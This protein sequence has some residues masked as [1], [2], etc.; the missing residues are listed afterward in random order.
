MDIFF[1]LII[2]VGLIQTAVSIALFYQLLKKDD[3]KNAE[4]IREIKNRLGTLESQIREE[5]R[6]SRRENNDTGQAIRQ[7]S[8]SVLTKMNDSINKTLE[9]NRH[10]IQ[11]GIK[12][13]ESKFE[14]IRRT[15]ESR[16]ESMQS[17]NSKKL[18]EMRHVV[19]EKLQS[20]LEKRLSESFKSVSERLEQVHQGLGEMQSLA[21]GVGDLKKVLSNVKTRGVLGE[22]QLANI[23]ENI[24]APDHYEKNV[25][26]VPGT[27]ENVE[28]ALKL[29]GR[30]ES[31]SNVYL[32]I[33]SKF[34]YELYHYLV[35]AHEKGNPDEVKT[36]LKNLS[37]EI[38]KQAKTISEKYLSPPH[39]TDFGIMFLPFEGL[40]AEVA[41]Q[42]ELL[43]HLQK[44][45][46][47][48]ITGPTT[49][50]ALLN[51]L[52]LGFKTLAIEKRSSEVW[53]VLSAVKTEFGKF[54]DVLK[55]ARENIANAGKEIDRLVTTRTDQ[56]NRKLKTLESLPSEESEKFLLF[57]EVEKP[58][59]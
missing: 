51:S 13:I 41:R 32:P 56:I 23:L 47:I 58:E 35:D 18:D 33:D 2:I 30:K 45:Y 34:P 54:S 16:I 3:D 49:L 28:F 22:I 21:S 59:D 12:S 37:T 10:D 52:Q 38:K 7:E 53:N 57:D 15:M 24:L 27:R 17:E 39:T 9:S 40:Y 42:P 14:L 4:S 20:T 8:F 5:F 46:K 55:K 50:A 1:I 6:I 36:A 43:D 25:I 29:P 31:D 26:T 44:E 11:A 19:E 48:I